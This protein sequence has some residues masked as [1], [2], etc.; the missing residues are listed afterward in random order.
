MWIPHPARFCTTVWSTKHACVVYILVHIV[1]SAPVEPDP[2]LVQVGNQQILG[3]TLHTSN[4][5]SNSGDMQ[6]LFGTVQ[7][8]EVVNSGNTLNGAQGH[9]N[10]PN[11]V[12]ATDSI[13]VQ[14]NEYNYLSDNAAPNNR[15]L[16]NPSSNVGL[17][18]QDDILHTTPTQLLAFP[19]STGEKHS[20]HILKDDSLSTLQKQTDVSH[21]SAK[22]GGVVETYENTGLHKP[23]SDSAGLYEPAHHP[24]VMELKVQNIDSNGD[25]HPSSSKKLSELLITVGSGLVVLVSVGVIIGLFGCCCKKKPREV[26]DVT[27]TKVTPEEIKV[28]EKSFSKNPSQV[29]NPSELKAVEDL[30]GTEAGLS[31]KDK[32]KALDTKLLI[33]Q[34]SPDKRRSQISNDKASARHS[35]LLPDKSHLPQRS[36]D[37]P[38][39][40]RSYN[41]A[42]S[43]EQV[44][45]LV[46]Q[47][48]LAAAQPTV[49]VS[50]EDVVGEPTR[51]TADNVSKSDTQDDISDKIFDNIST[52][53]S[54]SQPYNPDVV[55]ADTDEE[56]EFSEIQRGTTILKSFQRAKPPRNRSPATRTSKGKIR[57]ARPGKPNTTP[58]RSDDLSFGEGD[59]AQSSVSLATTVSIATPDRKSGAFDKCET[60]KTSKP[61]SKSNSLDKSVNKLDDGL[62]SRS[63]DKKVDIM[64][65]STDSRDF[66]SVMSQSVT[67]IGSDIVTPMKRNGKYAK[68]KN[69]PK[70]ERTESPV[71]NPGTESPSRFKKTTD[72]PVEKRKNR[73]Q[74]QEST[75]KNHMSSDI[76]E[77]K[78]VK[79]A[80]PSNRLS[81]LASNP[82]NNFF[83]LIDPT[84]KD[85]CKSVGDVTA[86]KKK[87]AASIDNNEKVTKH[88]GSSKQSTSKK[89]ET[90]RSMSPVK[91]ERTKSDPH[92]KSV[93]LENTNL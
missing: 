7:Y 64:S 79:S 31:V 21:Q 45:L 1:V 63:L 43:P 46:P 14:L 13:I 74:D 60:P 89:D 69:S 16:L 52:H 40:R 38:T 73:K 58:S 15:G 86:E 33:Q 37:L 71:R 8:K 44:P 78:E 72:S 3:D 20:R 36:P 9:L 93:E 85:K 81:G 39:K 92:R 25:N 51:S 47:A 41:E 34:P 50:E 66:E 6:H 27:E 49:T 24:Q 42:F 88:P 91:R 19:Q 67:S 82:S 28:N 11:T 83:Y 4:I 12:H 26:T 61:N 77:G 84:V 22:D 23:L 57:K 54:I 30:D 59:S 32:I 53:S 10:L 80:S 17:A 62:K 65:K 68:A 48:T 90:D 35:Q 18:T 75:E 87:P 56:D 70:K 55:I 2:S 29:F 76:A 5:G